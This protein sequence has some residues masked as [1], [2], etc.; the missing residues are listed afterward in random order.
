MKRN[1]PQ[2]KDHIALIACGFNVTQQVINLPC[3]SQASR[4]NPLL[5]FFIDRK[6]FYCVIH[7]SLW[8][9]ILQAVKYVL[10]ESLRGMLQCTATSWIDCG[11][12]YTER[13]NTVFIRF[14]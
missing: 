4:S 14:H 5:W 11:S 10:C 6:W 8:I 3:W 1:A 12:S 7:V 13:V 2:Q 9:F